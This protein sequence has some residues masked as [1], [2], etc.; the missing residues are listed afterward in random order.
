MNDPIVQLGD[1]VLRA[2]AKHIPK[3]DIGSRSLGA[4][5]A[6]MKKVL[7]GEANGV[8]LAAPQVGASLQLFVVAGRVFVEE[9]EGSVAEAAADRV[10]I[11][12]EIVRASRAKSDMAEGCL[13][14]RGK[15]GSVIRHEKVTLK[16]WNE[17]GEPIT[18]NGSGLLAQIFQHET[19]HLKGVLY[20]DKA[21]T[22]TEQTEEKHD[23]E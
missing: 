6:R 20:I 3:K 12:P 5:I 10:F 18:V 7:A 23:E 14:V 1:P 21:E 15:Y 9:K 17:K 8:A 4:L 19:D 16:A 13:S 2:T 11:N 22:L